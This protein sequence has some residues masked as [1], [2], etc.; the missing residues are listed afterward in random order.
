MP[1]DRGY[2]VDWTTTSGHR[3]KGE[4]H[5]HEQTDEFKKTNNLFVRLVNDDLTPKLGDGGKRQV[6]VKKASNCRIIGYFD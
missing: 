2:L 4:V 5:Y 6:G 3:Q 1:K